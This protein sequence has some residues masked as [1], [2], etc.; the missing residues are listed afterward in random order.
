[1]PRE[2]RQ[3]RHLV[4]RS[5]LIRRRAVNCDKHLHGKELN[6]S[7]AM[8]SRTMGDSL[9]SVCSPNWAV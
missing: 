2:S 6:D 8:E 5:I 1:M 3:D 7:A 9:R 4:L